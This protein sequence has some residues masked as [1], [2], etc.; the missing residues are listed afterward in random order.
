M[1]HRRVRWKKRSSGDLNHALIASADFRLFEWSVFGIFPADH[2]WRASAFVDVAERYQNFGI[3]VCTCA[4]RA[5]ARCPWP[6][7]LG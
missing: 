6:A 4:Y 1:F 3:G 5:L 2:Q 7:A